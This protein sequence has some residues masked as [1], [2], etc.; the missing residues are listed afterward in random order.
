MRFYEEDAPLYA[1]LSHYTS[2]ALRHGASL[3]VFVVAIFA[4]MG[5]SLKGTSPSWGYGSLAVLVV[6]SSLSVHSYGRVAYF[7]AL[8]SLTT[9][10]RIVSLFS[11]TI[12]S[13]ETELRAILKEHAKW[14]SIHR[15]MCWK[16]NSSYG[17]STILSFAS[18][19]LIALALW[20]L[21]FV[22]LGYH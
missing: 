19:S 20:S 14:P 16:Y 12:R 13:V 7:S 1:L 8:S 22:I 3:G 21:G 2:L 18:G 11:P 17:L 5:L 4:Y 9:H 15:W 10:V 6:L